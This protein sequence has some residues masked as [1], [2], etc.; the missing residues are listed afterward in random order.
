MDEKWMNWII[1]IGLIIVSIGI[2]LKYFGKYL[3]WLGHLPGDVKIERGNFKFYC[4]ITTMILLSLILNLV[5]RVIK[6]FR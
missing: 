4:P 3:S 2:G 6:H 5:I 1:V